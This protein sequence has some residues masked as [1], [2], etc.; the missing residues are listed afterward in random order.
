M[1]FDIKNA[2][3]SALR[4]T[5]AG[6]LSDATAEIQQALTAKRA[7]PDEARQRHSLGESVKTL[8]SLRQRAPEARKGN[9]ANPSAPPKA[10]EG[11]EFQTRRFS[12][13]AGKRSYKLYVPAH[14]PQGR[15]PLLVMLHGCTQNA[16]D[17]AAGTRMNALAE[18]SG[19]LVAYPV[20]TQTANPSVCWNWFNPGDQRRGAGEPA[21]IAGITEEIA[22][23]HK[24]DPTRIYIAGLSA[25]GAMAMVMGA[26]YPELFSGIGVHSGLPYQS[27]NDVMSAFGA[28]RGDAS[29]VRPQPQMRT[30]IFHGDAD[31]TVHPANAGKIADA[32]RD[33]G[34][35]SA[36]S[37]KASVPGGRAY[38]RT[39]G[40][41]EGGAA[42][43]EQWII[44]GGGHAW[45]GGS[46]DGSYTDPQGPDASAEMLRFFLSEELS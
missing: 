13:H 3:A 17:F 39:I 10:S 26:A 19:M 30:I 40:R 20:Q 28:M 44:K 22:A 45:A 34:R 36:A 4:F 18:I 8:R 31:K 29:K 5:Q 37:G 33:P 2:M 46:A 24:I 27:A 38:I 16:D 1:T 12:C 6:R 23:E 21:I 15:R 42:A 35:K 14:Q 7:K 9:E 41:S 43:F 25:G 32:R 11:A